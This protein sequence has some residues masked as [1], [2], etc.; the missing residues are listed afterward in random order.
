MILKNRKANLNVIEN[1][2]SPLPQTEPLSASTL[3]SLPFKQAC[4]VW[5]E[6]RRNEIAPRTYMD[7]S[8][9]IKTLSA[10]FGEVALL[11][12]DGKMLHG[13]QQA[14]RRTAGPG[15]IRK[16]LGVIIQIRKHMD[17]PITDYHSLPLS[18]GDLRPPA[19][20]PSEEIVWEGVCRNAAYHPT[21]D[22]AALCSLLSMKARMGQGEILSL[23]LKD[24]VIGNSSF[25]IVRQHGVMHIR[26]ERKVALLGAAEWAATKLVKRAQEKCGCFEPDHFLVPYRNKDRSYDPERPAMSYRAGLE[27]L[28]ALAQVKFRPYDLKHQDD[29][30]GKYLTCECGQNAENVFKVYEKKLG[31]P[32]KR[33]FFAHCPI[34]DRQ[35]RLR[36]SFP[37]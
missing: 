33:G 9:Y 31:H 1:T 27:H 32:K 13:Y 26:R 28:Q 22:V 34:C 15:S 14:R 10:H 37:R 16:E 30:I 6:S 2:P 29:V 19:L 35:F 20:S 3:C 17:R 12:I 36:S 8:N 21:W 18:D 24:V 11:E 4:T 23:R 5:L 7:Y 25:C